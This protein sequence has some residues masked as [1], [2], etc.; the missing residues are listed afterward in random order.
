MLVTLE[1]DGERHQLNQF[2]HVLRNRGSW[3]TGYVTFSARSAMVKIEGELSCTPEQLVNA[4][5]I[6]PD[7]THVWCANT[8]IGDARVTVYERSGLGWREKR[9]LEG[10]RRAHFETGGRERDPSVTREHVRVA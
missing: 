1:L 7:G 6:D 8:E 10:A 9:R 3:R 5:Y 2:R 4:P